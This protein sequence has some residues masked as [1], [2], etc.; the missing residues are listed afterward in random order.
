MIECEIKLQINNMT[1]VKEK[2]L[3]IGFIEAY[4]LTETD[5][6][7]DNVSGDIR[8]NDNA[9]RIRKTINHST[10]SKSSQLNFKGK[11]LDSISVSRPEYET[12]VDDSDAVVSI[13]NSLGYAPVSPKVV[14]NRTLLNAKSLDKKQLAEL[15]IDGFTDM[16]SI[17]ACLDE[18]EDLGD[19]LELEV[20]VTTE[21]EKELA[22]ELITNILVFLGYHISDTT[23]T[24]YLSALQKKTA[25]S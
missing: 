11:K 13:L 15:G 23:A 17:N 24:S 9:L 14:K 7:F 16:F 1:E 10:K 8:A 19:F 22:L 5:T 20:I 25:N 18:V 12:G 21:S 3:S 2:L 6:Y 4:R